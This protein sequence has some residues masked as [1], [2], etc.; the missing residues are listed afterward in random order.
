MYSWLSPRAHRAPARAGPGRGRIPGF[1]TANTH[2]RSRT[3]WTPN[4][5]PP[6]KSRRT[7]GQRQPGPRGEQARAAETLRPR[8]A[9]AAAAGH[10]PA[11][12]LLGPRLRAARLPAAQQLPQLVR[13]RGR[14][15]AAA[16]A[17]L[18]A[19]PSPAA[20]HGQLG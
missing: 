16:P 13:G 7:R 17:S 12:H 5:D 9:A 11:P 14:V 18:R 20:G 8:A 2:P 10:A 3:G 1:P 19:L 15:A 4:A 6:E